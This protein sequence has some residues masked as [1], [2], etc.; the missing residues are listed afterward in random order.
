MGLAPAGGRCRG[1]SRDTVPIVEGWFFR[2]EACGFCFDVETF[3][4]DPGWA[5][6]NLVAFHSPGKLDQTAK[7]G[8]AHSQASG[9]H[10]NVGLA[11]G[12][13]VVYGCHFEFGAEGGA[14]G[15]RSGAKES[16]RRAAS[17]FDFLILK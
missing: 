16:S 2:V 10:L 8:V 15:M 4:G 6:G 17:V 1:Y 9:D 12:V 11:V 14:E 3:G 7:R 13:A 5:T